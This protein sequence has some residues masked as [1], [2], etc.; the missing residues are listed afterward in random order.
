MLFRSERTRAL[1]AEAETLEKIGRV[2][3]ARA[4]I[5][6]EFAEKHRLEEM[7][8]QTRAALTGHTLAE[9]E[10]VHGTARSRDAATG[11]AVWPKFKARFERGVVVDVDVP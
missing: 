4:R 3:D 6:A 9:V 11:W 8:P 7:L 1:K 2:L 10:G 5:D